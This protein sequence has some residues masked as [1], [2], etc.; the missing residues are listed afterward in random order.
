MRLEYYSYATLA[1]TRRNLLTSL[2]TFKGDNNTVNN[3]DCGY[4]ITLIRVK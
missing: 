4:R 3:S 1:T 2:A